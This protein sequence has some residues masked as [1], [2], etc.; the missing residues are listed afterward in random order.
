MKFLYTVLIS[1]LLLVVSSMF[2]LETDAVGVGTMRL[3]PGSMSVNE[4]DFFLLLL[5]LI[6]LVAVF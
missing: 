4:G 5:W 3:E 6:L 1:I 2:A